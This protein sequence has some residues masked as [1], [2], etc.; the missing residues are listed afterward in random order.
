MIHN[1]LQQ[2][3]IPPISMIHKSGDREHERGVP[4]AVAVRHEGVGVAARSQQGLGR[5]SEPRVRN[6]RRA[7][8]RTQRPRAHE[9]VIISN[10]MVHDQIR[11]HTDNSYSAYKA[12]STCIHACMHKH[13]S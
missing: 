11:T 2:E 8:L 7:P 10:R 13:N 3:P 9:R 4:V 5:T 6:A 1:H 12:Q